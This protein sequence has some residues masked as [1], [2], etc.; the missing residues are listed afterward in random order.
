MLNIGN[1]LYNLQACTGTDACN[2]N[3]VVNKCDGAQT[4][5]T[6]FTLLN[7][8]SSSSTSSSTS[9]S[10]QSCPSG[11]TYVSETDDTVSNSSVGTG[12]CVIMGSNTN[13]S[14]S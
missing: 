4:S 6:T 2:G 12:G 3:I 5:C 8:L 1:K 9:T 11:Y 13:I 10:T 7:N 14:N